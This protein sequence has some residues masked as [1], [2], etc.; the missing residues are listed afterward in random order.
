M[1]YEKMKKSFTINGVDYKDINGLYESY[2]NRFRI[3]Q[4]GT[5]SMIRQYMKAKYPKFSGAGILWV[6]SRTFANGDSINVELNRIPESY[7]MKIDKELERFEYATSHYG[8]K[9][10]SYEDATYNGMK[11]SY[12]TKY[13][14][15]RNIPPN[16]SK[17]ANMDAPDWDSILK[18]GEPIKYQYRKKSGSSSGTKSYSSSTDKDKQLLF[19]FDS[20]WEMYK[21]ITPENSI[22][23]SIETTKEIKRIEFS[24]F[25]LLKGT[26]L[27]QEG[28]KWNTFKYRFEK[29]NKIDDNAFELINTLLTK[30]YGT[31]SGSLTNQQPVPQ[32]KQ[33]ILTDKEEI[34]KAIMALGYLVQAGDLEAEK[35]I[36]AL[37][38]LI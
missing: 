27:T 19:K 16:D 17:E 31:L 11:I 38:Y 2:D 15:V 3:S 6:T 23:Y 18:A 7:I 35:A 13:L 14:H 5:A 25:S 28:F 37:K 9:G 20:G 32:T 22:I 1:A 30:Y 29:W 33:S 21:T 4:S 12:G 26:M 36:K 34:S 8:S 24:Q 10:G